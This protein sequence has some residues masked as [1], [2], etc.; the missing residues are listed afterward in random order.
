VNWMAYNELAWTGDILAPPETYKE[1]ALIYVEAINSRIYAQTVTMLH[2]GCGAG[3]HDF[4]FKEHF[5]VTGVDISEGMLALAKKRN[6]EVTYVTGDMRTVNLNR[7]FDLVV[8]PDS[9]MYMTTLEYLKQAIKNAARHLKIEG[10]LLVVAHMKEDFKN[11]NFAYT[12]EKE[13]T[14]ITVLENNHVV[15]DST[16]EATM[17]YLIRQEGELN[18]HHEVQTLG[19]F[20]YDQWMDIFEKCS[21]KVDEMNLNHLYD[22]YLLKDG[23]YKLKVFIGTSRF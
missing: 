19:L 16:Y 4:H 8:I 9:I 6:P 22:K 11:N 5:S 2:L 13:K 15:S 7:K 18:I 17:A 23:E 3:G 20:S 14:H 10:I 1:E 21:L 12:G